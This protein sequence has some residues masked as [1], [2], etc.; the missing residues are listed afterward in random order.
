MAKRTY[1]GKI[2]AGKLVL[3]PSVKARMEDGIRSLKNGKMVE[4]ELKVLPRRSDAQN[5][6][7]WAVCVAMLRDKFNEM[8]HEVTAEDTHAFLKEKFN[9]KQI[10]N[11]EGEL[12]GSI[13][14]STTEFNKADMMDYIANIQRWAAESLS[15]YIPDPNEQTTLNL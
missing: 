13:G 2:E 3:H 5:R 1:I 6:F 4:I 10:C 9:S 15:L 14:G 7:Y 12:I 11:E 8:G